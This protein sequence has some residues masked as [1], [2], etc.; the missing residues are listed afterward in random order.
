MHLCT[1][2]SLLNTLGRAVEQLA[3]C[4]AKETEV[5]SLGQ[6]TTLMQRRTGAYPLISCVWICANVVK[7]SSN[8][9]V[10]V[11]QSGNTSLKRCC[12]SNSNMQQLQSLQSIL[13]LN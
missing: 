5:S 7:V 1:S 12:Q 9:T 10:A 2:K 8:A 6:S 3:G 4:L 11:L 13:V